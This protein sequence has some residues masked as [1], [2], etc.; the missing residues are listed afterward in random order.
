[1]KLHHFRHV[2]AIAELGSLRAAARSLRIAQ[3]ALTR[4]VSELERELGASLFERRARGMVPTPL[5]QAFVRRACAVLCEIER[6]REEVDQ[7]RGG[8]G[9]TVA[10]GLSI[11][12]HVAMLPR[13]LR[14]FRTRYPDAQLHI[15]EGFYPTLEAELRNGRIDFYIGPQPAEAPPPELLVE[16]MFDNTRTVLARRGHPRGGARSL[17]ELADAEW[18]TTSITSQAEDELRAI[19]EEHGLAP[20]RLVL[21]SQ[22]AMTLMVMLA[23]SD[24]LA[25]VPVQWKTFAPTSNF[26]AT[27]NVRETLPAPAIVLIRRRDVPLTPAAAHLAMLLSA[28]VPADASARRRAAPHRSTVPAG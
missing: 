14:P 26:L 22:S 21:R 10:V 18:A 20:P 16:K 27:I 2:V 12:P 4:S 24:L 5:G 19:F 23:N 15:I 28:Y 7:L 8:A 1:M 25:M 6:A 9:G 3:P 17:A 13:A 11:A